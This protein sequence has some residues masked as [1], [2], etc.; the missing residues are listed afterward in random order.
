MAKLLSLLQN[1]SHQGHGFCYILL[2][3]GSN[4]LGKCC[5]IHR[6]Q[7]FQ[8]IFIADFSLKIIAGA[9]IQ[10]A[11]RITHGAVPHTG[12]I[13]NSLFFNGNM[14]FFHNMSQSIRNDVRGN[15]SKIIALTA[16]KN[17]YRQGIWL[18]SSQD[19]NGIFRRLLQSLQKSVVGRLCKHMYLVDDIDLIA[20]THR[21]ILHL[22]PNQTNIIHLIVASSIHFININAGVGQ[23]GLTVCTFIAGI[24][25][26]RV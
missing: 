22:F 15:P 23:N 16:G 19:E 6:A 25:V 21:R 18:R 9:L 20:H 13:L 24:S 12:N 5:G 4:H 3:K 17:G 14:L 1:I 8:R 7:Y 2:S 26:L 10:K 11:H